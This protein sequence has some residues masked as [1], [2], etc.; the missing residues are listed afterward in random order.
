MSLLFPEFKYTHSYIFSWRLSTS[1]INPNT[2]R[3]QIHQS[4]PNTGRVSHILSFHW[5]AQ[6]SKLVMWGKWRYIDIINTSKFTFVWNHQKKKNNHQHFTPWPPKHTYPYVPTNHQFPSLT[7]IVDS[8]VPML[9]TI[10]PT[11]T[12]YPHF[13]PSQVTGVLS[14]NPLFNV[15]MHLLFIAVH[16]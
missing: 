1:I 15:T 9:K 10:A 3:V 12:F 2:G 14:L 5:L 7:C 11:L 6:M 8:T 4:N 13:P 16:S